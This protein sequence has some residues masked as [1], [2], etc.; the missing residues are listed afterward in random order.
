MILHF[1]LWKNE[2]SMTHLEKSSKKITAT[3]V[4][5]QSL[6]S[7]SFIMLFTVGSIIVV[8]LAGGNSQWTGV[9]STLVLVGAVVI[10]YPIGRLMD[11]A[12]R[13]PGL[14]LGYV[15]GILG[16][17]L[18][19]LAVIN[20]SLLLF[21]L[22]V[23]LIGLTKG[24]NDLGR[25]AA[26][27]A[28][29]PHK[30]ARAISLIVLAG[31]VGSITGPGLIKWTGSL[32]ESAGLP[33]LSG[34]WFLATAFLSLA[35]L[36]VNFF[37]RPDPQQIARQLSAQNPAPDHLSQA[38][39]SF[40]EILWGDH[41]AKIAVSAMVFGQLTLILVIIITPMHM[42]GHQHDMA[43]ISWVIM[44]NALGRFGLSFLVGWLVDRL[45]R[46]KMITAGGVILIVSCLLAPLSI[47]VFWLMLALFLLGLGWNCC[48]VAGSTLLTDVLRPYEKGK[49]QGLAD[50]VINVA[51]G[52]GSLGGGFVFAV[53][54]Y[55]SM[56]WIGLIVAL[57]PLLMI[58]LLHSRRS[59]MSLEGTMSS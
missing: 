30:R 16:T 56:T 53:I 57:L 38:G 1:I 28:N 42:H 49:I 34:P 43:D 48:F 24:A 23:L 54:G 8:E 7:A 10:A 39:R 50:A 47:E 15:F 37:L 40:Q 3:L 45:G 41:R 59:E 25:Y 31:T 33:E 32:A 11:R 26:A 22:G 36:L 29:A 19:G 5:V 12:G 6:V 20:E 51:S 18:A 2:V 21:L 17:G 58:L 13:R 46:I 9:P 55:T 4:A 27:E 14:A 35:L 44:A 52:V